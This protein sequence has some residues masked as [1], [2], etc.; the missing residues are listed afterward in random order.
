MKFNGIYIVGAL[1]SHPFYAHPNEWERIKIVE[2]VPKDKKDKK[3][4]S[5]PDCYALYRNFGVLGC[6][7]PEAQASKPK[8]E[9]RII[10]LEGISGA[11]KNERAEIS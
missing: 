1:E 11:G 3:F 9:S 2:E 6:G 8:M 5:R 10:H 4:Y 7:A